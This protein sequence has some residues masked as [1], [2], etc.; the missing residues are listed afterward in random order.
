MTDIEKL[1]ELEAKATPGPWSIHLVDD[2]TIISPAR[3]VA[4]TCDS[5]QTEREDGYNIEYE[6]MEVDAAFI[7]AMRNALP[8]LLASLASKDAENA[9]L[10]AFAQQ[11]TKSLTSLA[12]GGS[13]NFIRRPGDEIYL[14]DV[15]YCEQKL[16]ERISRLHKQIDDF[17]ERYAQAAQEPKQLRVQLHAAESRL[18]T[19]LA[20]L[21]E[22]KSGLVEIEA[23]TPHKATRLCARAALAKLNE[24]ERNADG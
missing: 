10:R 4:T 5:A 20:A 11:A 6:Q 17:A 24:I 23:I 3:E 8:A 18:T 19:A 2:T 7:V 9:E 22:A 14:A 16:R 12:G 13:E 21:G 15:P 1:K